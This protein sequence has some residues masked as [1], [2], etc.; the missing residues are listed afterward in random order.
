MGPLVDLQVVLLFV[1]LSFQVKVAILFLILV[2]LDVDTMDPLE[3][4]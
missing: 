1:V 2:L 4:L 3:D